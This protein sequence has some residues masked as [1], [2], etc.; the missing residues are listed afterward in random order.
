MTFEQFQA[1]K[2]R[3]ASADYA[4]KIGMHAEYIGASHVLTY[5]DGT[6][7]IEDDEGEGYY[8]I[9]GRSDWISKDLPALEKRL[10]DWC[11]SEGYFEVTQ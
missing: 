11:V 2:T 4:E 3:E 1:S 8:L 9:L 7:Y 6:A 5:F 10:F